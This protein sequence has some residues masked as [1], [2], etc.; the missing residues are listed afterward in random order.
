MLAQ[1]TDAMRRT[2]RTFELLYRIGGEEFLL[3]L[4]GADEHDA[5][6][7][8]ESLRAAVEQAD[9]GGLHVTCS[10][11]WPPLGTPRRQPPLS[12]G[13]INFSSRLCL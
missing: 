1:A 12:L 2:L 13:E 6:R 7:I 9:P 8:A 11:E 10:F 4:P 3:V 5:L